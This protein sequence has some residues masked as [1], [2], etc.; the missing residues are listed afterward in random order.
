VNVLNCKTNLDLFKP[1][2][3]SYLQHLSSFLDRSTVDAN[4]PDLR[5]QYEAQR[6]GSVSAYLVMCV[7]VRAANLTVRI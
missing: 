2:M 3:L 5:P 4:T 7:C 1:E 6:F